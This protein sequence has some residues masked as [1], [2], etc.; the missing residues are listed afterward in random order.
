[1]L[2]GNFKDSMFNEFIG[3]SSPSLSVWTDFYIFSIEPKWFKLLQV[4]SHAKT[5]LFWWSL[6]FKAKTTSVSLR[7][8]HLK[9]LCVHREM[10]DFKHLCWKIT[11]PPLH[12]TGCVQQLLSYKVWATRSFAKRAGSFERPTGGSDATDAYLQREFSP[13][14]RPHFQSPFTVA[15]VL[16]WFAPLCEP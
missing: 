13:T 8:S 7:P 1:M 14:S 15:V 5:L 12:I 9:S 4:Y 3:F 10:G 16:T 6:T 11:T 2:K